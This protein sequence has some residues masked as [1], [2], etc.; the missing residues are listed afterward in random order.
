M[1]L[2]KLDALSD[3]QRYLQSSPPELS[4]LFSDL[5]I[6]VT[7]F[8]R[9]R[10]LYD[11]LAA[12]VLPRLVEERAAG[13]PIRIWIAG[14]ATGEEAYSLAICLLEVLGDQA[15]GYKIQI[16][17]TDIDE[18]ALATARRGLYPRSIELDLS[19]QRLERFL[20]LEDQ[21]YRVARSVRDLVVFARHNLGRDPPFARMDLVS[22]RNVLIYMQPPLQRRILHL[23]HYSLRPGGALVLG[24]SESVGDDTTL[25]SVVDR[26]LK[27]YTKQNVLVRPTFETGFGVHGRALASEAARSASVQTVQQ[28]ADR[29]AID[30]YA[31]PGVLV[32]EE[33]DVLQFRGHTGPYLEPAPGSFTPNLL[34]LVRPDLVPLVRAT[35]HNARTTRAPAS[36][37]SIVTGHGPAATS[38]AVDVVPVASESDRARGL[39]VLFREHASP[40]PVT[41][42]AEGA[43]VDPRVGELERELVATKDSLRASIDELEAANEELQSTNEELQSSNEELQSTNEELEGSKEELESTN[44]ELAT[45]NDELHHRMGQLGQTN[46]D[47][48][49]L[50]GGVSAAVLIV[51][52]E[53]RI[54]AYSTAA[55]RL[56]N[57]IPSDVGRPVTYIRTVMMAR[58]LEHTVSQVIATGTPREQRVRSTDGL[59]FTMRVLPYRTA[60]AAIR[61]A[62]IEL[63]RAAETAR[64][65]SPGELGELATELLSSLPH[66]L[67]LLDEQLRIFWANREFFRRFAPKGDV[68]GQPLGSLWDGRTEEPELWTLLE[69]TA[70]GGKPFD[71]VWVA[72]PFSVE[73]AAPLTFAARRVAGTVDRPTLTLVIMTPGEDHASEPGGRHG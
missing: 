48:K 7:S 47:L 53:L 3:Y 21:G 20:V 32:N 22:C 33:L 59:W 1:A 6:G 11:A 28:I 29:A 39:L 68:F 23:V 67:M 58:D 14:C 4:L 60:D 18:Q 40:P 43:A 42:P 45:V 13:A 30:R 49:N 64:V 34:K 17:A 12:T 37:P 8:F 27:I 2:H 25:F 63:A 56:L 38:V 70:S 69:D 62:T 72:R 66:A 15:A 73:G 54:R 5:L 46:D 52:A 19:P 26:K 44:E 61:G 57:L 65:T 51:S 10:E 36:S 71:G 16:F 50:L 31:P 9:D 41:P 24:L 55:E 35:I